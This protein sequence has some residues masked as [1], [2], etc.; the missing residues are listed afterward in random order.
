MAAFRSAG[1]ESPEKLSLLSEIEEIAD[2]RATDFLIEIA[3]DPAEY[4]LART[5]ALRV[6]EIRAMGRVERELVARALDRILREDEDPDVRIYAARTLANVMDIRDAR[7]AAARSLLDPEE[8]E[9]VRHNAFFAIE[10]G[11]A[12]PEAIEI[13]EKCLSE[14]RFRAGATRVLEQWG[15]AR[16]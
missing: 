1:Q 9:D 14:E 15:H 5:E 12:S 11:G 7:D 10:R 2:P 4:D 3:A 16:R 13:M 8:D 6:L